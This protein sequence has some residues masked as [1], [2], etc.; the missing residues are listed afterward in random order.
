MREI[1]GWRA[2]ARVVFR[3]GARADVAAELRALGAQRV[4]LI[5]SPRAASAVDA[6]AFAARF[7]RVAQHVPAA[8]VDDAVRAAEACAADAVLAV[9]GGSAIGLAKAVALRAGATVA[10]VPTTF[11]GSEMTPIWGITDGGG[12]RTG[13]DERARPRLV[14]YDPELVAGLP[15]EEAVASAFNALAHAVEALYAPD[16]TLAT[17]AAAERAIAVLAFGLRDFDAEQLLYGA[18]LAGVALGGAAMGLHHKLC[19]V[20]GGTFGAPHAETHAVLLPHVVAFNRAGA[21]RAI[22]VVARALGDRDAARAIWRLRNETAGVA[23]LAQLGIDLDDA[24]L[25]RAAELATEHGY[26]N[27]TPVDRAAV[28]ALLDDAS[29]GRPPAAQEDLVMPEH[30]YGFGSN[31][32][33]EALPGALP[34]THNSPRKPPYGLCAEQISGTPFTTHRAHASRVWLYK[35]R[36]SV[37]TSA[38][39]AIDSGLLRGSFSAE[40]IEPELVR[41]RPLPVPNEPVDWLAGLA[42]V[43]GSGEAGRPGGLAVHVYAAT[44]DMGDRCFY[45]A[46]GDLLI[47]PQSG[48]LECITELGRL[49]VAP[50]ELFV[51]PRGVKLSV[52]LPDGAA[53]GF[54]LELYGARFQ[55]PERGPIGANGL[56]DERHFRAPV[57]AYEDRACP[58]YQVVAK[59]GGRLFAATQEWSPF[60]V[61]AWHGTHVPFAYDL[62][63]FNA[64]GSVTW[65]H[66]DPSILTVLT[67]PLG[68]TGSALADVVVFPPRWDVA[69]GSLRPPYYHR[70]AATELNMVISTGSVTNGF[71]PGCYFL[72]PLLTGHGVATDSIEAVLAL[73]DATADRPQPGHPDS[74]WLMFESA[75]PLATTAWARAAGNRDP[76]FR[77]LFRAVSHFDS[78]C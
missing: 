34:R 67:S 35:I 71:E 17:D 15:R 57:A 18:H 53:R 16:R 55:L 41:W 25:D 2:G 70:N 19:H 56:A 58:G 14:I 46:D 63:L 44:A 54:V 50:G 39:A 20:L 49:R 45:D 72:T 36:P 33:S 62:R 24:M 66:P 23:T 73:D 43:A 32:Q 26:P 51:L 68:T 52:S 21:P 64:M 22:A 59:L 30:L 65:D 4:L 6:A 13:R 8:L 31:L 61:V 40:P 76:A 1:A 74:L 5:A 69:Q 42:T 37:A 75:L 27:P 48:A 78:G 7:D 28:R 9:G 12:K 10:C 47:A 60:D 38:F 77:A 29:F 11:S 3:R